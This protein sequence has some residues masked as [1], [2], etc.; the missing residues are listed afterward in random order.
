MGFAYHTMA[1]SSLSPSKANT[2][3]MLALSK[4]LGDKDKTANVFFS[5]FSVSAG[6]GMVMLGAREKKKKEGVGSGFKLRHVLSELGVLCFSEPQEP[7]QPLQP[8]EPEAEGKE[9]AQP[10]QTQTLL[11]K[12]SPM[13]SQMQTRLQLQTQIQR[14]SRLPRYLIKCLKPQD[15][16]DDVHSGFAQVLKELNKADA[17]Y[18]LSVANRLFGSSPMSSLSFVADIKKNYN[19][20]LESVDFQSSLE[21]TRVKINSWWR[22][23]H[24]V[25][26]IKDLLSQGALDV[27]T[28]LVLVNAVYFKGNWNKRFEEDATVDA[29]FRINKN[30]TKPVKMMCQK[31]KFSHAA[32]PEANLQILEMPYKGDDLSMLIFLPD[33][34]ADDT[35]GLEKLE[36]E[37][38]YEKFVE[39]TRPDLMGQAEVEVKLPRFKMEE[40]YDVND[41]LKSMGMEDAFDVTKSN[42]SGI[43][44]AND[45]VLSKVI[46]KAFVE[47]N[48]EGTEAAAATGATMDVRTVIIPAV[49]NA[50]H[51]FLFYIRHNP[52]KTVLFAG[53][54]CCPE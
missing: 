28:K 23:R 43:S 44:P 49:F 8:Q 16:Q 26:K 15:F 7:P 45:L 27:L 39:W 41:V 33:E 14:S 20:D 34:I 31:S 37:L 53:R 13:Q 50:D 30:D 17:P 24:K 6:L 22:S 38:T 19:A 1:S 3:F 25:D 35:T 5:P 21:E 40:T 36:K 51:P 4:Q 54:F 48:E 52:T 12:Q 9:E 11:S 47:V 32:F 42:F 18:A 2:S 10:P 29:Q 46:H